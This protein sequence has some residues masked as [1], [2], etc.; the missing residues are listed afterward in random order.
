MFAVRSKWKLHDLGVHYAKRFIDSGFYVDPRQK[1][2]PGSTLPR[3]T[4]LDPESM[5]SY[6]VVFY[7]EKDGTT[8][9]ILGA[10]D[11]GHR[12]PA[13][14]GALPVFQRGGEHPSSFDLPRPRHAL[15]LLDHRRAEGEVV[16]FYR[17]T[18]VAAGFVEKDA[19]VFAKNGRALRVFSKPDGK[20]LGVVVLD[21][22]A[23]Q[24]RR[25][26]ANALKRR[27]RTSVQ[28]RADVDGTAPSLQL[29]R[30]PLCSGVERRTS[31]VSGGRHLRDGGWLAGARRPVRPGH[32]GC[33]DIEALVGLSC[34][35]LGS[36]G[37]R[38]ARRRSD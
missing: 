2:F 16:A 35:Q 5:W 17:R 33:A 32:R 38:A 18:L 12:R 25:P 31:R 6:T 20:K 13:H 10:A 7:E 3:L 28:S 4:A 14:D 27:R 1:F 30:I 36:E 22:A 26:R 19:G 9:M 15:A 23:C 11:L 29:P 8:T 34:V 37:A 24:R 21:E